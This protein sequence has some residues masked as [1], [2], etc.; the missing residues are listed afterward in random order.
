M[1]AMLAALLGQDNHA[2]RSLSQRNPYSGASFKVSPAGTGF[3]AAEPPENRIRP[4]LVVQESGG[5][6][7]FYR[8]W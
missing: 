3:Q 8:D 5:E 1:S 2:A 6:V 7:L 4:G